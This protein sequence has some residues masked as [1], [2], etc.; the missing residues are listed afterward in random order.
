MAEAEKATVEGHNS[1]DFLHTLVPKPNQDWT[2][3]HASLNKVVHQF[4]LQDRFQGN[5][6]I[7]DEFF[8]VS[9][10]SQC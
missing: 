10:V 8:P 4:S 6:V 5:S 9:G 7:S 1:L 2:V 3:S